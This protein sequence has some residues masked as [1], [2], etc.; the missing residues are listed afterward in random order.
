MAE[1]LALCSVDCQRHRCEGGPNCIWRP[2]ELWVLHP[3]LDRRI[4]TARTLSLCRRCRN[5]HLRGCGII[6]ERAHS[7]GDYSPAEIESIIAKLAQDHL[8]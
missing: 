6:A 7:S 4:E 5:G 8:W 1:T 2:A 3:A